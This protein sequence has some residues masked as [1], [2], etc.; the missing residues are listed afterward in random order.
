MPGTEKKRKA[1][2]QAPEYLAQLRH[3]CAHLMAQAVQE[4]YPGTKIA[5]GPA[6]ENGFY[7]DFDSPHHFTVEDLP[8]IE[9][10]MLEVA[11]GNHAFKGQNVTKQESVAYWQKRNERYKLELLE[12]L[13]DG[14]ITHYSHDTFTDLCRGNH[15]ETTEGIRHIKLTHVSGAY[16]RGNENNPMLQRI[17]GTAWGTKEELDA[18]LKQLEEAKKR[19]HRKLGQELGLFSVHE[20]VGAG[21]IFWHPKG[22]AIRYEIEQYIRGLL[23][24]QDYDF[25]YTPHIASEQLYKVSGHL[26]NYKDLMYGAMDIEGQPFRAKPM[27][28]PGHIMIYKTGLH[29]YR[30]LPIR[31]AEYG[32]VYRFERS[33]VLHGLLRVRGFTQDDA[34]IFCT[35]DHIQ[36]EV[37]KL[38]QLATRMYKDFGFDK[39]LV[40]LST[41][42]EKYTG[43]LDL[44]EKAESGLKNALN[45]ANVP[46]EIEEGGGAFYGPKIDLKVKDAIGREWQL[47]TIQL[48]FNLPRRFGATYRS[49]EGKDE[50]VVM[51]H[52]ALIGSFERFTGV[53]IE[54]YAGLFP[55][56]LAPV[57]ASVLTLTDEQK[58]FAEKLAAALKAQGLRVELDLRPEKIGHKI[59]EAT[60]QKIPYMLVVGPKE[61]EAGTVSLRLRNGKN[62]AGLTPEALAEKLSQEVKEKRITSIFETQ[63]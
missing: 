19:D 24:E 44:W 61:A 47:C 38:I 53:L 15:L 62:V 46:F 7:Y 36:D 55:L 22:A 23:K 8:K 12:G 52:R 4:L 32:T 28:C 35:P 43:E 39:V 10:R 20:E 58:P 41:R 63:P 1:Q 2:T 42:P 40:F 9:A 48:D 3:S 13:Q 29:S 49:S 56:W 57:Q 5:I 59:R 18:Y 50:H 6:I 51:I 21:L 14:Q 16:W 33:G 34:H 17:Y 37:S 27:N 30:E 45:H 60:L 11:K 31:L 26:E 25:V 54:H